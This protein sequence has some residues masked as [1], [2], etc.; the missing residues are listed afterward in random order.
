[1]SLPA[2]SCVDTVSRVVVVA[3]LVGTVPLELKQRSSTDA[4]ATLV[5]HT[6]ASTG[7][8]DVRPSCIDNAK[9]SAQTQWNQ[10]AQ[11]LQ[12]GRAM[13]HVIDYFAKSHSRSL[14]IS[15]IKNCIIRQLGYCFL[16][17]FHSNYGPIFSRFNTMH[18]RDIQ[19]ITARRQASRG[20]S[21][22]VACSVAV[23]S[24]HS[25][26]SSLAKKPRLTT[27]QNVH[28]RN[29]DSQCYGGKFGEVHLRP[30]WHGK[31]C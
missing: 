14:K 26:Q 19:P 29:K 31:I 22:T 21:S 24:G 11:L 2:S 25:V 9:S 17:A 3:A 16:L 5:P 10:E 18:E 1:V 12:R 30:T 6:V 27:V 4:C 28:D 23:F 15:L 8:V 13:L 7:S 20:S